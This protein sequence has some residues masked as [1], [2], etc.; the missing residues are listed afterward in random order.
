VKES[1]DIM[2]YSVGANNITDFRAEVL[3]SAA[4]QDGTSL[5]FDLFRASR[6][7]AK[8][9]QPLLSLQAALAFTITDWQ[10]KK[11]QFESEG[12][13]TGVAVVKHLILVVKRIADSIAW[14]A[15]GYDRL[16]IQLLAEHPEP[17]FLQETVLEEFGAAKQIIQQENA[18]VLVND[19]TTAL[20]H[21]DLTVIRPDGN[22]RIVE[23]K[24]G[25]RDGGTGRQ[26]KRVQELFHFLNTGSR[27]S[28]EGTRD[29]IYRFDIPI[30]THHTAV[31]DLIRRARRTGYHR[32]TLTDCLAVEAVCRQHPEACT[33]QQRPFEGV[34]HVL[35]VSN[36]DVFDQP[37]PRL[38]PYGVFPFDDSTCFEL[39]T[40]RVC[41]IATLNFDAL[42]SLF[43]EFGLMLC[44]PQPTQQEIERYSSASI[45][46]IRWAQKQ[47]KDRH[48]WFSIANESESLRASPDIWFTILLEFIHE[49]TFAAA[50][51][52]LIEQA[53]T[54]S[55]SED[56]L[57]RLYWGYRDESGIWF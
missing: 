41:L 53:R 3:A 30:Q 51:R 18:F 15:L 35:S 1:R 27:T 9:P 17:G 23:V 7:L 37:T 34:E 26:K 12:N 48:V 38:V 49:R 25:K 20:R 39:L 4:Y 57:E 21:G 19:I 8:G 11:R 6:H 56:G 55:L 2:S 42:V 43:R 16:L 14:R 54:L 5:L 52:Q 46:E 47:R 40:G 13:L 36:L 28:K 32:I 24:A 29:H 50:Q 31:S 10:K 33:R 45:A 44:L 22:V